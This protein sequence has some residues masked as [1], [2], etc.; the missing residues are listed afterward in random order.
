M[1]ESDL[2]DEEYDGKTLNKNNEWRN[3][4]EVDEWGRALRY[5]ILTKTLMMHIILI[6]LQ[7]ENCIY[8]YQQK[9]SFIYFLPESWPKQRCAL[10]S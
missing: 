2:L 10:V 8:S 5:A 6:I 9:I 4:V 3:G 7:T 1:I